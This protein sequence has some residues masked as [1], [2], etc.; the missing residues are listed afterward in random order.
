MRLVVA[1]VRPAQVEDVRQALSNAD[2]VRLSICDAQAI[3]TEGGP[4]VVSQ[5]AV[6]EV[7]VND[8]FLDR[9]V[10]CI[11]AVL[12]VEDLS[13]RLWVVPI[14]QAVQIYRDVRGPEAI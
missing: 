5:Q 4:A 7:A 10:D 13:A 1:L 12:R 8:D 14:D 11:A 9:A 3:E 6:I 2:I